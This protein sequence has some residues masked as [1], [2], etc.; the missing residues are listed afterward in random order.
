LPTVLRASENF[1]ANSSSRV[2]WSLA[3]LQPMDWATLSTSSRVL[4]T[5]TKNVTLMSARMLSWQMRPSLPRRSI[6]MVF[7]EMSMTS[8]RCRTGITMAPVN[9]TVGSSF[10]VF[11]MSA[12]P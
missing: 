8:A 7:T 5:R 4:F 2:R 1:A 11:T 12:K 10:I 9:V 3:R 6:S